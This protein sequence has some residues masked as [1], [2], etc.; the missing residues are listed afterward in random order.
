MFRSPVIST[1]ARTQ[2]GNGSSTG[3]GP[4]QAKRR[5]VSAGNTATV[6]GITVDQRRDGRPVGRVVHRLD[7]SRRH[8]MPNREARTA[9]RRNTP[10]RSPRAATNAATS[11]PPP[12]PPARIR[13]SPAPPT[14]ARRAARPAPAR[15]RLPRAARPAPGPVASAAGTSTATAASTNS[16]T[17]ARRRTTAGSPMATTISSTTGRYD[18]EKCCPRGRYGLA[19]PDPTEAG[20]AAQ[21]AQPRLGAGGE[22]GNVRSR[23][24]DAVRR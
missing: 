5:M 7:L 10:A 11:A 22:R 21:R 13:A 6:S 23:R 16:G 18:C 2:R 14:S 17:A 3:A 9:A 12:H 20:Q 15:H 1:L 24:P 8:P 4:D 19:V